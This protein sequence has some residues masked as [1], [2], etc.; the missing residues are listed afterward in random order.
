MLCGV[1][2]AHQDRKE[3]T[4][5]LYRDRRV[6]GSIVGSF[7]DWFRIRS[8]RTLHPRVAKQSQTA[9]KLALWLHEEVHKP[10]SLV[11]RMIDKVQ[12]ASMQEAAL[13]DGLYIFQHAPSL[14]GVESLMQWRAMIDE[15][16]DPR[17]IWVSCGVE[18]VEDMKA[19]MLQAFESLL[20]DFP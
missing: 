10:G 11:R 20:R 16:R 15:G 12:H 8:L 17:L 6:M 2:V 18:D 1:L 9:Q 19:Y 7:E 3:W 5:T 13:K 14:G 4:E